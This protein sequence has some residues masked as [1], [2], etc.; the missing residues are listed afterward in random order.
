MGACAVVGAEFWLAAAAAALA[1]NVGGFVL[2]GAELPLI[3]NSFTTAADLVPGFGAMVGVF[4]AAGALA[5]G[6]DAF[7]LW[8]CSRL[9]MPGALAAAGSAL[10]GIFVMRFA[11]YMMHMTVGMGI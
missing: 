1:L 3:G 7:A 11:F 2:Q 4:A 10:V 6:L 5:V 8:G 9:S